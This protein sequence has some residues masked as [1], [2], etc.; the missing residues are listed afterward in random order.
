[1]S[2]GGYGAVMNLE[3]EEQKATL[4]AMY[5]E[6]TGVND[7]NSPNSV[8]S[9]RKGYENFLSPFETW[10]RSGGATQEQPLFY[11][12]GHDF[13]SVAGAHAQ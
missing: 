5:R 11:R 2:R 4:D 9:F 12:S 3:A 13:L 1:M 7:I 10:M 6:Y 8:A